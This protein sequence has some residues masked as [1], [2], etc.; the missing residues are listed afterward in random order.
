MGISILWNS[1][2]NMPR[3]VR[4][5]YKFL[6]PQIFLPLHAQFET[7]PSNYISRLQ[8]MP[9]IALHQDFILFI[10]MMNGFSTRN[11]QRI[12]AVITESAAVLVSWLQNEEEEKKA[13]C[14]RSSSLSWRNT[15][16][17][18]LSGINYQEQMTA[19]SSTGSF[20]MA[21]SSAAPSL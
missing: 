14:H 19:E 20:T 13:K 7:F 12:R 2:E 10:G 21:S 4:G 15:E 9:M 6:S 1:A 5:L 18:V 16:S 17:L 3:I 8:L 11:F